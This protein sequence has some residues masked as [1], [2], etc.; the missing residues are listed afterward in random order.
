MRIG[1]QGMENVME[2]VVKDTH[3]II[4]TQFIPPFACNTT[5][6]ILGIDSYIS[7]D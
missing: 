4:D 5:C 7:C 1:I 2:M 6:I 3:F